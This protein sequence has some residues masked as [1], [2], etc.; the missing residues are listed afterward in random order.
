MSKICK[1]T[2]TDTWRKIESNKSIFFH[3]LSY[4]YGSVVVAMFDKEYRY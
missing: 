1:T 4:F 3:T 2:T